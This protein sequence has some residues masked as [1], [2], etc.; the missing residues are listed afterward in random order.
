MKETNE[1]NAMNILRGFQDVYQKEPYKS[2]FG[3]VNLK[4]IAID[5]TMIGK[6]GAMRFIAT[7]D[8]KNN[9]DGDYSS[10]TVCTFLPQ[11]SNLNSTLV[12]NSD[13]SFD[14]SKIMVYGCTQNADSLGGVMFDLRSNSSTTYAVDYSGNKIRWDV[15]IKAHNSSLFGVESPSDILGVCAQYKDKINTISPTYTSFIYGSKDFKNLM[16][17]RLYFGDNIEAYKAAGLADVSWSKSE[18]FTHV[19]TFENDFVDIWQINYGGVA[20]E[21]ITSNKVY[22]VN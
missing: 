10:Y 15:W 13:G 20:S 7:G 16:L 5:W 8:I 12:T 9:T 3:G 6:S 14:N 19:K 18:Y 4:Y 2:K 21:N 17:A 1:D 11:Y 22:G